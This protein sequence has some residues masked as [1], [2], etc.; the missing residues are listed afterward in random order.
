MTYDDRI[1]HAV[2]MAAAR[3]RHGVKPPTC[4]AFE[5]TQAGVHETAIGWHC[6]EHERE[7]NAASDAAWP[8]RMP[9][10]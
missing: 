9:G 7:S 8:P 10:E 4:T 5:C 6:E 1:I 3:E 2:E